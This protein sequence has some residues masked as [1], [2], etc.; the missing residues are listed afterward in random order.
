MEYLKSL[1][2]GLHSMTEAAEVGRTRVADMYSPIDSA[3]SSITSAVS[4]L[5][6]SPSVGAVD[7]A[8]LRRVMGGLSLAQSAVGRVLS[9]TDQATEGGASTKERYATFGDR[10]DEAK[11]AVS[12]VTDQ[13]SPAKEAVLST[14]AVS[15]PQSLPAEAVSSTAH[16]LIVQPHDHKAAALYLNLNT[17]A[18]EELRRSSGWRWASQ[19]RLTRRP[20]RQSVGI[21]DESISLRGV[22]FPAFNKVGVGQLNKLR[23]LGD[24]Q[25]PLS[26][27]TGYG[28]DLGN[29]CLVKVDEEQSALLAGGIPRKQS[30]TLEF[31]RYGDDLSND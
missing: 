20:A 10:F 15:K 27:I 16:L 11:A 5:Q 8:R 3:V 12:R 17:A 1:Q 9:T 6:G 18:F 22:V 26:I 7:S 2:A 24:L 25:Q 14:V 30:F 31:E 19:E 28:E 21:G 4:D 13:G 29:W 23:S